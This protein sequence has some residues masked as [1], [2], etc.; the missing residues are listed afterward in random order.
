M[1]RPDL[2]QRATLV[3]LVF[4]T[5][6]WSGCDGVIADPASAG[7]AGASS[8]EPGGSPAACEPTGIPV[9]RPLSRLTN[10]Q[11]DQAIADLLGIDLGASS[12]F[13]ADDRVAG[14]EAGRS[15]SAL[16]VEQQLA[17]AE[18]AARR[19]VADLERILPCDPGTTPAD[20]AACADQVVR[21]LGRRAFRRP[22][23]D[24]ER[25]D[26]LELH[27]VARDGATFAA[28]IEMVIQAL[29]SSP[30]FLYHVEI[31]AEEPGLPE[32]LDSWEIAS[33]LGFFLWNGLPDE[34]LLAAAEAGE[35]AD[36]ADVERHARRMLESPRAE[37]AVTDFFR[38]WL[39]LDA[40]E[41]LAKD[42]ATYPELDA[43]VARDL[44]ASLEAYVRGTFWNG[45]RTL[46]TLLLGE[47]AFYNERL[48][49]LY[50]VEGVEGEL[51]QEVPL[52]PER[53]GLLTHPALLALLAEPNQSDPIQRGLFVRERLLCQ[54]LPEPPDD[55]D[56]VVPDPTPGASTR[57]RF[58]EH[59]ANPSCA[60]CHRL[61]DPI[62]FGF[63]HFDGIG[64]YRTTDEGVR[65]DARGE[66]VEAG[67][68]SGSFDGGV[69]LAELLAGSRIVSRCFVRQ[70]L[71]YATR[72]EETAADLCTVDELTD[73]FIDHGMD[74]GELMVAIATSDGFL[75]RGQPATTEVTQ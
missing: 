3:A 29:L 24:R 58:A 51:L 17:A 20:E 65:V 18:A 9:H 22:L 72:R 59:T 42:P 46:P 21:Q 70:W 55:V 27:R 47:V 71:R 16:H 33:R 45:D 30:Q 67:D 68:A 52:G 34:T 31:T 50:G 7:P 8:P 15:I 11:Y 56:L 57:D 74:V 38:Q 61:L 37:E 75:H 66:L 25:A 12:G 40:I 69:E 26:L 2:V 62:G 28:G 63:E 14:F 19:A 35:L 4:L 32:R 36:P 10:V 64:R 60:G 41:N 54:E 39:S 53:R 44:R 48:A 6:A 43:A 49:S 13:V 1:Q 73:R 5:A 23:T